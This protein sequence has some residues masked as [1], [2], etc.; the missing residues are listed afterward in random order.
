M[1]RFLILVFFILCTVS[2]F[3]QEVEWAC[4]VLECTDEEK[5]EGF[6]PKEV[7]GLPNVLPQDLRSASGQWLMG[8]TP[9]QLEPE[10]N[11]EI[12]VEFCKPILAAQV[13]IAESFNP[14]AITEVLIYEEH[15]MVPQKVYTAT[16]T[17]ISEKGRMLTITFPLTKHPVKAVK[18]IAR[19]DLVQG[20]NGIDAIGISASTTPV[21][22]EIHL[23][24]SIQFASAAV[25]LGVEINTTYDEKY[26]VISPDGNTLYFGR[27]GAPNNIG[28][29][30]EDIWYS[31]KDEKGNW[32]TAKNIGKPL[33]NESYNGVVSITPDGNTLLLENVYNPDGS[34]E[35]GGA[36]ISHRTLTGWSFPKKVNIN[37]FYNKNFFCSFNLGHDGKTLLLALEGDAAAGNIGDLDIYVS[38]LQLDGNW[39]TPMNLGPSI[40]T[41]LADGTPF[42]AADGVTMYFCSRGYIGF[43]DYDIYMSKRLDDTWK[44]WTR[45]VNLGPKINSREGELGFSVS[46]SGKYAYMYAYN[47]PVQKLDIYEVELSKTKSI[48]PEPVVLISGKVFDAKTKLPLAAKI[49]YETLPEGKDAGE[50]NSNPQ[51]G[52]YK[53]VLPKGGRYAYLA[54]ANGYVAVNQNID[55]NELKLY[56]EIHQDLYLVPI[57]VG[58]TVQLNNVFFIQSKP[59][60]LPSSYPELERM[61]KF[62]QANP[63]VEI[64]LEGHTDNQ[65]DPQKNLI[66]SEERV[67]V[68]KNYLTDHG[69]PATRIE[70]HAFGGSQPIASN[71]TEETRKLNRR[72]EFKILRK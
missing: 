61:I 47:N 11:A 33:N 25:P 42:L 18:V 50:A 14:G 2:S 72:V 5:Y 41:S 4:K 7:L 63:T 67:K 34:L 13:S 28:G 27:D 60:L 54:Q 31:V 1:L 29:P 44:N 46:A 51:N 59:E 26:P 9:G 32:T 30:K 24:D 49:V 64:E 57:E 62:M 48:Q 21:R 37:N 22:A 66:L 39:S 69:I 45:P 65:G 52:E 68:V 58:Q 19:P 8:Y 36:S 43:G 15:N 6:S 53:I 17:F 56:T 23:A 12:K 70:L 10:K 16:P 20:W 71:A 40:N 3:A 35:G 38:F 55:I